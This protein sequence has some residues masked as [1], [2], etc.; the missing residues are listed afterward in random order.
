MP[1]DLRAVLEAVRLRRDRHDVAFASAL[2]AQ[3][4]TGADLPDDV[5][6]IEDVLAT[7]V[8]PLAKE[9]RP[10]LLIVADGMSAAVATEIVDDIERRYDSWLECLPGQGR[11]RTVVVSALPSL[12]EVSRC[13]LL[14]GELLATGSRTPSARDSPPSCGRTD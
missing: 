11:R 6:L 8:V 5:L 13:S 2:A 1:T 7:V 9:P 4:S 14:S 10:V 3:T 12:T